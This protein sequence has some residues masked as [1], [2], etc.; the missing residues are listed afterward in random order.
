MTAAELFKK[1]PEALALHRHVEAM[2]LS[3]GP[4]EVRVSKSQIGFYRKHP[5]AATWRPSQYLRRAEAPLALSVYLKHRD[6]SSRWKEI[7][8]PTPGRFTHHLELRS[9]ADIDGFVRARL[10]EAWE[11]AV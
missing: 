2:V 4:A 3:I 5:F 11:D 7:V 8:E 6:G 1:Y 9:V 10:T